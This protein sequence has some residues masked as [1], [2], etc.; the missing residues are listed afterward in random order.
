MYKKTKLLLAIFALLVLPT[1][2]F[3]ATN[4]FTA[5]SNITVSGVTFGSITA[6]MLI[7]SGSTAESWLFNSGAFSATNPGS[8]FQV[9]SSDSAVK[10]I[11]VASGG[12]TLVCSENTTPGTS[13]A[14]LPTASGTYTISPS[15]TTAC[16]SL[17]TALSNTASYNAFP[18]CGA[19]SCSAG[20]QVSGS[21]ASATC[22]AIPG[23][24]STALLTC[25]SGYRFG[26]NPSG[27]WS[28]IPIVSTPIT[29]TIGGC[30]H[31]YL[32]SATTGQSCGGTTASLP[33]NVTQRTGTADGRTSAVFSKNLFMGMSSA[34]VRRLQTLLAS[35]KEIYPEGIVSGLYGPLTK[36]AVGK[37]QIKYGV[38][39]SSKSKGYGNVGPMTRA[40]LLVVFGK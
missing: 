32:F 30:M 3:A 22:V 8:A 20:Y 25:N 23:G 18:T 1:V 40:K 2:G 9:G 14:T 16:T 13:Y 10:S 15:A 34:D 36:K 27:G 21:G 31:G 5:N 35:D 38:V 17:C 7:L 29:T 11:Q 28:C 39:L 12:S 4:D 26:Q 6:D 24:V 33:I 37:F 19:L